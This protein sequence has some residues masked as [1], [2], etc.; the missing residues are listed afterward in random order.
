LRAAV[1]PHTK[2]MSHWSEFKYWT[3]YQAKEKLPGAES[4]SIDT[5]DKPDLGLRV[6]ANYNCSWWFIDVEE[7]KLLTIAATIAERVRVTAT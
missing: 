1:N 3:T 7:P 6:V 5:D 4:C 2:T